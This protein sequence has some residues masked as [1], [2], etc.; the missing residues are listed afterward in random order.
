MKKM[1]IGGICVVVIVGVVVAVKMI[2]DSGR[3]QGTRAL[4]ISTSSPKNSSNSTSNSSAVSTSASTYDKTASDLLTNG[5][6]SGTGSVPIIPPMKLDQVRSVLPYGLMVGGHVTPID[7][8]YY[9]GLDPKALRDTYDVV[10][11]AD[12]TITEITHRGSK[13]GTPLHSVNVPSSD[14]YRFVMVHTCSF[15]TYVDLVT[16][17]DDSVKAALPSGWSPD[18]NK[19]GVSVPI[20]QGQVI[21]HIG[22]QTLDF[23]VWDLSQKPL[24]GLLVRLAYD[25][26]EGWKVFSAPPSK[27]LKD[28]IKAAT[29]AKY[30]RTVAP[31]DG[32]IDYDIEGKL[33]GTWFKVGSNGYDGGR[34]TDHTKQDYWAGHLVF[35]PNFVDPSMFVVSIGNYNGSSLDKGNPDP[36]AAGA[37]GATQ[38]GIKG[39]APDPATIDISS[40]LNKYELVSQ[41]LQMPDGKKWQ[42]ELVSG[43]KAVN[44]T[45]IQGV[46]LV[47]LLEAHKLKVEAFPGKT[48][49][50]VSEFDDKAVL[51]NRGDDSVMPASTAH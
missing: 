4:E 24:A 20:K 18:N 46:L 41:E 39:N 30:V 12:G 19:A 38:F 32:K 5:R 45:T 34:A 6:C 37:S 22:G 10:A 2:R 21:G 48:A 28:D 15:L 43:I 23:A 40:G 1:M 51:Y 33:I 16:S 42:G 36:G 9:N 49:A 47:Q 26:A 25:N 29:I 7:H 14:E 11:P 27:Y 13:T 17:L 31:V 8:Q 44:G 3:S 35:A 50:Q